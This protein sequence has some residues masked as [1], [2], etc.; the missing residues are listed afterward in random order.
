[1]QSAS[2]NDIKVD[3]GCDVLHFL[4]RIAPEPDL[5]F[6]SPLYCPVGNP[7]KVRVASDDHNRFWRVNGHDALDH[8][9][10]HFHVNALL[11]ISDVPI[12]EPDIKTLTANFGPNRIVWGRARTVKDWNL[13]R[14]PIATTFNQVKKFTPVNL[15]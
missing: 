2:E 11:F 8:I 13:G 4:S 1:M 10:A 14:K 5:N 15:I 9:H 7:F 12:K 6:P 3:I